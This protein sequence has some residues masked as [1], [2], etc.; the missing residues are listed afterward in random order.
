MT[1]KEFLDIN[2]R[3][4]ITLVSYKDGRVT[5]KFNHVNNGG[6]YDAKRFIQRMLNEGTY[7]TNPSIL[8]PFFEDREDLYEEFCNR[9]D[10]N[11]LTIYR[12]ANGLVE[13]EPN[14]LNVRTPISVTDFYY[15]I[16]NGGNKKYY[17]TN[18]SLL[19]PWFER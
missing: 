5:Y 11:T 4:C 17:L 10:W 19:K 8:K 1:Y 18:P 2:K 9:N 3:R 15:R 14:E 7:I 12:F 6:T 16:Y 13:L